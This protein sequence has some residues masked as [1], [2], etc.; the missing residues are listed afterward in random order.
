MLQIDKAPKEAAI[1]PLT[2]FAH[3]ERGAREAAERS[4]EIGVRYHEASQGDAEKAFA[5]HENDWPKEAAAGRLEHLA[6]DTAGSR[7]HPGGR[8]AE[9]R[10]DAATASAIVA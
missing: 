1:F 7:D 5:F 2:K 9:S 6:V 3:H 4:R 8:S 10:A